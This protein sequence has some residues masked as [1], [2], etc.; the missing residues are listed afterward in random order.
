[1]EKILLKVTGTQRIDGQ[2]DKTELTTIATLETL[3]DRYIVRYTE[4]QAPP[5]AP[6][7]VT[8]TITKDERLVEMTRSG[9][10]NSRLV[11]EKSARNLC[12]YGTEYGDIL[13]GIA[14]HSIETETLDGGGTFTFCY[15]IDLNGALAS[16]NEVKMVYK[17][18]QEKNYVKNN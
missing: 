5:L 2:K 14:G 8:V 15:D 6:V 18:K 12:T 4:Q 10:Y 1:M 9:P 11:I 17:N 7:E 3:D 13:M 16:K